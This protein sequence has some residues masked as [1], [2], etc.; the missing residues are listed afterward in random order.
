MY[1]PLNK[2]GVNVYVNMKLSFTIAEMSHIQYLHRVIP[3]Q[4][5]KSCDSRL[6]ILLQPLIH[7]G[8][9]MKLTFSIY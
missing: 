4:M 9:D 7:V 3:Y 5:S 2:C 6:Q 8:L 1:L